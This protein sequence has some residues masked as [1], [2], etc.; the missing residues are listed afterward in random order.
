M[1]AGGSGGNPFHADAEFQALLPGRTKLML[2]QNPRPGHTAVSAGRLL[3]GLVISG[4]RRPGCFL[5]PEAPTTRQLHCRP[6]FASRR[7]SATDPGGGGHM[8][9]ARGVCLAA[10]ILKRLIFNHARRTWGQAAHYFLLAPHPPCLWGCWENMPRALERIVV[11]SCEGVCTWGLE[12]PAAGQVVCL[13]KGW[14]RRGS[15]VC[16]WGW[17]LGVHRNGVA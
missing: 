4:S 13:D 11:S 14:G 1:S 12:A 7:I 6:L 10:A 3:I 2:P 8:L 15:A 9:K 5:L 16:P 17:A